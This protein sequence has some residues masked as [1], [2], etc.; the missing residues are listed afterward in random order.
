M[1]D[2]KKTTG[3]N[4]DAF[5]FF[6]EAIRPPVFALYCD[7]CCV[8]VFF[9]LKYSDMSGAKCVAERLGKCHSITPRPIPSH[10]FF[11]YGCFLCYSP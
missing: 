8:L 4:A 5:P 10:I 3:A 2:I 6:L 1:M 9:E 7:N 11:L